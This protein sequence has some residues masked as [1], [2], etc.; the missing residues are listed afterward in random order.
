MDPLGM[1]FRRLV[2]VDS[3]L[4]GMTVVRRLY[5]LVA[6]TTTRISVD[7]PQADLPR[8][9]A[10]TV[11]S[12]LGPH[13]DRLLI[14]RGLNVFLRGIWAPIRIFTR[15][16]ALQ[17]MVVLRLLEGVHGTGMIAITRLALER[18]LWIRQPSSSSA[19]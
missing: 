8:T 13:R 4:E 9:P 11:I 16:R 1:I 10:T 6:V 2:V 18:A 7:L 5:L 14:H 3:T 12:L 19:S 17:G 15:A